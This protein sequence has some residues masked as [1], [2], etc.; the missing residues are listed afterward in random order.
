MEVS[1]I[2]VNYNTAWLTA[3][4]V[5]SIYNSN[6]DTDFEIIIVDNASE[7]G[8]RKELE[9]FARNHDIT[10]LLSDR[11]LGFGGAN[12]L[13]A[14]H[15]AGEYLL[16]LN[17]DTIMM[18]NAIDI[19]HGFAKSKGIKICG[20]NLFDENRMPAHSYWQT[21]PGLFFELSALVNNINLKIKYKGSHEHNMT[22]TPKPVAYITGADLMICKDTFDE[23]G[24]FDDDYFMYFEETDLQYRAKIL[25]ITPWSVPDAKTI[26]LESRSTQ[27]VMKKMQLFYQSRKIF[28]NKHRSAATA[29]AANTILLVNCILRRAI[30]F[31][32]GNREKSELWHTTQKSILQTC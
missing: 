30:F 10:L 28:Y 23:L 7:D 12:N 21:M 3:Q 11:N 18:N 19:L 13:G 17:P 27:N 26:H 1:V 16:L 15:A 9:R 14:R 4:A 8:D 6:N 24:G 31:I 5:N 32:L 2:I 29:K 20:G 25:G 22:G